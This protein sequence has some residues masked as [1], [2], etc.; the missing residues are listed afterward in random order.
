MN[1][2]VDIYCFFSLSTLSL[3]SLNSLERSLFDVLLV[4]SAASVEAWHV[5]IKAISIVI[6]AIV[7]AVF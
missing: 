2:D 1:T 4:V 7:E 3:I 5:S 6:V